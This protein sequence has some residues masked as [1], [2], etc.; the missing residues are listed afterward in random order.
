MK[1]VLIGDHPPPYGGISVHVRAL[2]ELLRADGFEV[3]IFDVTRPRRRVSQTPSVT[4][5]WGA[6]QLA[7]LVF[8]ASA[9][10]AIVH[11]HV[12]GHNRKSWL[13]AMAATS[14][15]APWAPPPLL[16]IHS[17]LAP[18]YLERPLARWLAG[19][20]CRP[21]G[22]VLCANLEI[23]A[24][25]RLAGVRPGRLEVLPAFLAFS[26][27]PGSVPSELRA[28]RQ[29]AEALAVS[30]LG[31]G[32]EYGASLLLDAFSLARQ[33]RPGL[34][35]ATLGLGGGEEL[36]RAADARGLGEEVVALGE[37][38]HASALAVMRSGDLFVRPTLADGDASS[39][40]EA[41]S[42]GLPVVATSVVP[43]PQGVRLSQPTPQALSLALLVAAERTSGD[44]GI[45]SDSRLLEIYRALAAQ[46]LQLPVAQ[47]AG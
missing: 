15:S 22:R 32:P 33:A 42:L 16:T 46:P 4:P 6:S 30:C 5:I 39:I 8:A 18:A 43:R 47:R 21:A 36:R 28:F 13:L 10:G 38:D 45:T 37:V 2:G 25:L 23:A 44:G 14:L 11:A 1:V 24:A 29:G 34:R 31:A 40:R 19:V 35:L 26:M 7:A 20:A 12:C 9:R 3:S 27:R 41:L 17:G